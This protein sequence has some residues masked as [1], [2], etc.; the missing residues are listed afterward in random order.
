[1]ALS[2]DATVFQGGDDGRWAWL[3]LNKDRRTTKRM[4]MHQAQLC[5]TS[6]IA[7]TVG[8]CGY[9]QVREVGIGEMQIEWRR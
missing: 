4:T 7:Q 9:S 5:S 2:T 8:A 3:L 6:Q 1:M